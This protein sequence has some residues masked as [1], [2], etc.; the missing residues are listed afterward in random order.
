[1]AEF[2]TAFVAEANVRARKRC[3]TVG[4]VRRERVP[5][6][7][8]AGVV[9]RG[10]AERVDVTPG[11]LVLDDVYPIE[12]KCGVGHRYPA[13]VF[14]QHVFRVSEVNPCGQ[15]EEDAEWDAENDSNIQRDRNHEN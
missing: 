11:V 10:L 9:D 3:V 13:P 4:T 14:L 5:I 2:R 15:A 12:P 8:V 1:M 6:E 7:L